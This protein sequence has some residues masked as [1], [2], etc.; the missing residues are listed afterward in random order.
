MK[1]KDFMVESI[2]VSM[3]NDKW[4]DSYKHASRALKEKGFSV[5]IKDMGNTLEVSGSGSASDVSAILKSNEDVGSF[6]VS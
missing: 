2:T 6:T 3:K 5:K 4:R 1:L